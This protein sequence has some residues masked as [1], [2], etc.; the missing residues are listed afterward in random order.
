MRSKQC[1]ALTR[2]APCRAHNE[3]SLNMS[4]GHCLGRAAPKTTQADAEQTEG[5]FIAFWTA[6]RCSPTQGCPAWV[7]WTLADFWGNFLWV[8]ALGNSSFE[9]EYFT[10]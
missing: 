9:R 7:L 5:Q 1:S 10:R 3:H 8:H 4:F 6:V 2:L